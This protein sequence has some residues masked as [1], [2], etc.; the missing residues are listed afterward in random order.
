[1][2]P[3]DFAEQAGIAFHRAVRL[4]ARARREHGGD[5]GVGNGCE[6][7]DRFPCRPGQASVSEREPGPSNPGRRDADRQGLLGPRFRGDDTVKVKRWLPATS[8]RA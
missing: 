4:D 6:H 5:G 1:M 2:L 8:D 7:D 3:I